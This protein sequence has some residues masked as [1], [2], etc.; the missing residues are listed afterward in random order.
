MTVLTDGGG[1]AELLYAHDK[2]QAAP[3]QGEQLQVLVD[4]RERMRE[5]TRK[6]GSKYNYAELSVFFAANVEEK[7]ES[8]ALAAV[9]DFPPREP[10]Y[11]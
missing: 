6:D 8:P 1:F 2:L 4:V 9:P 10:S 3:E 11:T 5:G 7:A